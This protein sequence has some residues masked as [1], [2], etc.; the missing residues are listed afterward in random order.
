M[1]QAWGDFLRV[2]KPRAHGVQVYAEPEEL[3]ESVVA[4]LA[5]GFEQGEPALLVGAPEHMPLFSDGLD[6]AGWN[7]EAL[8]DRGLLA[9]ADAEETLAS[10]M[11]G[12]E[13]SPARFERSVGGLLDAVS[14]PGRRVR[15]FGEMVDV[16]VQR[17]ERVAA[18]AVEGL[19]N[20]LAATRDF[21]LLCGY[22][23]D[24][25]DGAVQA[26]TLPQICSS[27]SH[28]LPARNYPRFARAVDEALR[29]VLGASEAAS[30]YV[31]VSREA[32]RGESSHVPLA[33][34]LLMWV[35]QNMPRHSA[36]VLDATRLRYAAAA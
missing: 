30:I 25:F 15:V 36:L 26:G 6:E 21:S 24:V 29:D 3:A 1:R 35:A 31:R 12:D 8:Q 23:L 4:F 7:A 34:L 11:V 14:L 18:A 22:G 13:P 10:F 33:Q 17:G 2:A 5:A 9:L 19:W 16:L 27:H 32:D 28:V 20:D